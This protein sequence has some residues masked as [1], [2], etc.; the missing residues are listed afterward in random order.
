MTNDQVGSRVDDTARK[1]HDITAR[2][3]VILLLGKGHAGRIGALGAAME[4][5][6]DD[7]V[8]VVEPGD[9]LESRLV[10]EQHVRVLRDRIINEHD[11][12]IFV[13]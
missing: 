10:I 5:H 8:L 2:L 4:G 6:D 9:P 13:A 1:V 11:F 7:V 12:K 3:A